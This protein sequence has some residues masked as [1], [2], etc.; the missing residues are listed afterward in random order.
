VL[1]LVVVCRLVGSEFHAV[2]PEKPKARSPNLVRTL[3]FQYE[4]PLA[5]RSKKTRVKTRSDDEYAGTS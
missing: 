5:E 1:V 3:G 2:G 4:V